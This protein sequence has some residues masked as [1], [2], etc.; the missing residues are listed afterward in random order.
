MLARPAA[1]PMPSA[2][3]WTTISITPTRS[4]PAANDSPTR[5][6]DSSQPR[7]LAL[8]LLDLGLELAGHRVELAPEGGE[9]VGAV[10]RDVDREVAAPEALG[11]DQEPL[12][13]RLQAARDGD[14]EQR[15]E[16]QEGDHRE[17]REDRRGVAQRRGVLLVEQEPDLDLSRRRRAP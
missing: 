10:D 1:A 14:R 7:A 5:R 2:A 15:G 11:G 16:D 9:L 12:D 3:V 4:S 6:N 17:D 13:L 8:E